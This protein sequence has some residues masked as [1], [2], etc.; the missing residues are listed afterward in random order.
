MNLRSSTF[1]SVRSQIESLLKVQESRKLDI[2]TA[3]FE[4]AEIGDLNYWLQLFLSAGIATLGLVQNSAAVIIGAML[5]SPLMG[6]I[7]A[8]GLALALGDFYLGLKSL[9][10]VVA[11]VAAAV[12]FA[13]GIVWALPFQSVTAEILARTQP[14][15]LDLAIAIFSRCRKEALGPGVMVPAF[16]LKKIVAER[17]GFEPWMEFPPYT[18]SKRAPS[19]TRPSLRSGCD[20]GLRPLRPL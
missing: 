20:T 17:Q 12:L 3:N 13:A 16:P 8:T 11:S 15:L 7:I 5:V 6:P 9:L 18:L 4:A 10:N 19:T 2:Y 1:D 14:N